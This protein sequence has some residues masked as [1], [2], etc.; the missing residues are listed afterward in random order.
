MYAEFPE[1]YGYA[2]CS[3]ELEKTEGDENATGQNL[4]K[5]LRQTVKVTSQGKTDQDG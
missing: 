2:G 4:E 5:S 3:K 1:A